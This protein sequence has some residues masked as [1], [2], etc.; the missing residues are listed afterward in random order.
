MNIPLLVPDLP[1]AEELLPYLRRIDASRWYTN[2][3]PLVRE[4]EAAMQARF[5][6]PAQHAVSVSNATLG[7][8]VAL[9]ALGLPPGSRVLMPAL[10]FVATAT[11]TLR[12]GHVPVFC[13]VDPDTWLLTPEIAA[14]ALRDQR[15]DAVMP[16]ATY[17]CPCEAAG[18]DA[19]AADTGLPVVV[20]AA[21]AYGNQ[22]CGQRIVVVFSLHAT[23][24]LAAAE[25][26]LV[27]SADAAYADRVRQLSNFGI[28]PAALSGNAA[29]ST[30]LVSR[31]GTNAKLSEYHAAVALAALARWPG[32]AARRIALHREYLGKLAAGKSP[33]GTQRRD[34]DGVY[35]I[36]PVCL[37]EGV[38]AADAFR[39]LAAQ[40]I[41]SRRWYCPPLSAHPV[42]S[43][44]P[45]AGRLEVCAGL[46]ERLLAL[47]FHTLMRPADID[48]VLDALG[49]ILA[50]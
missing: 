8:E 13:D 43:A 30:G 42:F 36:F 46:G 12:A 21:G 3:G 25:G 40:G 19:F 35:S 29:G 6:A 47:P 24:S 39:V 7:L 15:V 26:G 48:S 50:D 10:T 49:R 16:V 44:L 20:D 31:E 34:P 23:K 18:W 27:L 4:F 14:R 41:G 1:P 45:V 32:S 5:A 37:P 2:F 9:L 38:P 11:A 33:A 22:A 28:D 17:G